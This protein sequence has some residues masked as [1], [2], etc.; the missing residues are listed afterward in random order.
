LQTPPNAE[1]VQSHSVA[2]S[3]GIVSLA[4]FSSRITGL[5]REQVFGYLFGAGKIA[6]AF[7]I[8]FQIPNLTRDLFAEGA[9]S[10]AFVPTFT[11]YLSMKSKQEAAELANLVAT[12]L[13]IVVGGLCLLGILFSP[14]LVMLFARG[15]LETPGKFELA[16][17]LTRIM[18]PFLLLVALAAQAMGILNACNQFGV[19]AT[20]STMFN[21]GSLFFGLLLGKVIGPYAGISEVHGM[22][23]GVVCGGGLQLAW[24]VPA[25]RRAG[26]KFRPRLNWS[27]PGL[28]RI[29]LL[30]GPAILGNAAVQINVTVNAN[31]ASRLGDGPVSWLNYAFRFMH[32]PIGIFGYAI[33]AA[34]LPA[35]SRSAA[36]GD[37]PEFR[38]TLSRS[39]GMVFVLTVPSAVGL[40]VLR[41]TIISAIYEM[42]QFTPQAARQT[43]LALA[44]YA[45]GLVGYAAARV[46]NPAFYALNDSRTPMVITACS[47]A[48]NLATA[49][50]LLGVVGLGH[51][52]LA[53]STSTVAIFSSMTLFLVM[54]SR[55]GGLYGRDLLRTFSRVSLASLVMGAVV[56]LMSSGIAGSIGTSKLARLIDLAVS[57][58][59]G[60]VVLFLCCRI[61]RVS[62]FDAALNAV[63]GPL[64]RRLSFLRA[65]IAS[66]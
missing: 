13:I 19:P 59:T 8:G 60:L 15:F 38:R 35:I 37:F 54:R 4:V 50:T 33:A 64:R 57:I 62:E 27:D 46:I 24:Q 58:P 36:K 48:I 12:A 56:W 49:L 25:L 32:L 34:T 43:A 30:M 23:F 16:V 66:Q 61:F 39:L 44:C 1:K 7:R 20:A 9:L 14:Q 22:A 63:A 65:R 26:F 6:D 31:L 2:R 21:I 18:F 51:E 3:A 28:R 29:L 11:E 52:G 41:E 40:V 47:V 17:T 42:G 10:A 5:V 45:V 55:I 53:L